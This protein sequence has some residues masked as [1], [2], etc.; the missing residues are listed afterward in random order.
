LLLFFLTNSGYSQSPEWTLDINN[1]NAYASQSELP[2]LFHSN[3]FGIFDQNSSGISL[4]LNAQKEIQE[5]R[6]L[7]YGSWH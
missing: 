6:N 2:F 1:H 7:D 5:D 4:G 3:K